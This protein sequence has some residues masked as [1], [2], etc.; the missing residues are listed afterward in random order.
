M[1]NLSLAT[2]GAVC[3][4]VT[5][6]GF[7][8]AIVLA[9]SSGVEVIIPET[10]EKGLEWI[11]DVQDASDLFFVSAWLVIFAGLF[12]LVALVGFYDALRDAGPVT[13]LAPIA[14]AVGLTLVTISHTIPVAMAY[15][16]APGYTAAN[17]ANQAS[18]AVTHDTLA[19]VSLLT[20]Y[21]GNALAWGVTVPLYA[22]AILTTRVLPR[23]IGWLGMVVAVFGGWLGLLSPA[24]SV[25]EGIS[26]IGFLGFFVFMASMGIAILFRGKRSA[27]EF[28]STA[29]V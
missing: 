24:S 16:L 12:G 18:L 14:G 7:V 3:A 11:A 10:G 21:V 28:A 23:W 1:R 2:V 13:I 9:T 17:A 4:L 6:V 29:G 22:V 25:I 15:E 26:T 20:N 5:V 19:S 8:V 27:T